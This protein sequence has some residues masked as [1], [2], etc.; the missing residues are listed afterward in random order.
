MVGVDPTP[1]HTSGSIRV[2]SSL[3]GCCG[4]TPCPSILWEELLPVVSLHG[5]SIVWQLSTLSPF[6]R[7]NTLMLS[8]FAQVRTRVLRIIEVFDALG[9]WLSQFW[10]FKID[11]K[12]WLGDGAGSSLAN[13]ENI[14]SICFV[15]LGGGACVLIERPHVTIQCYVPPQAWRCPYVWRIADDIGHWGPFIFVGLNW[16]IWFN[17]GSLYRRSMVY[18]CTTTR[19]VG[20]GPV[21]LWPFSEFLN[22]FD[23]ALGAPCPIPNLRPGPFFPR[24]LLLIH[25][26]FFSSLDTSLYF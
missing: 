26:A 12:F 23:R 2:T 1:H 10:D 17:L 3:Q 20:L 8:H 7:R 25:S 13:W 19:K 4:G 15:E 9:C 18:L 22:S 6:F 16:P 24:T 5:L 21:G 14:D 11:S